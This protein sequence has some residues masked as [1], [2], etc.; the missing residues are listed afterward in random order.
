MKYYLDI[1]LLPDAETHLGFIW[2]KVYQQLHL[3]LVENKTI[4]GHSEVAVS[5]PGYNGK[6]FPLGNKLRLLAETADILE[7]LNVEKWLSRLRDYVHIKSIS[8]IPENIE[9]HAS[10]IRKNIKG[11]MRVEQDTIRKAHYQSQKFGEPYEE[12][13]ERLQT[14][15]PNTS[16]KL[17]FI[18]VR[19]SPSEIEDGKNSF[20]IFIE[21]E[22]YDHEQVN[23]FTCYGLSSGKSEKLATVPWF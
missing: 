8:P 7:K 18:R 6:V 21:R 2:Q 9:K 10:F 12:C 22:L 13:L 3:A 11:K 15:A 1:T 4:D 23:T 16:S 19:R 20:N 5:F 14:S 17:P